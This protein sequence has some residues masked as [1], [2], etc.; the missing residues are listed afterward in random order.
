LDEL[1]FD[2]F[3]G[4]VDEDIK[5]AE[6]TF[7]ESDLERLHVQPVSGEDAAVIAPAGIGGRAAAASVSAVD[8]VVVDERGTMKKFDY[9][10]ETDGAWTI[11]AGVRIG[12]QKQRWAQAFAASAKKIACDFA[13]RLISGGALAGELL[14]DEDQVVAHQIEDFFNRQKR[15]GTSPWADVAPA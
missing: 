12:K 14:L 3:L 11:F 13:D 1:A 8:D 4:E 6:V 15:D 10:G 5:N 7:F 2:H 9:S